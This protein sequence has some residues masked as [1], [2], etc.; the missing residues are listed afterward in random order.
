MK[1]IG[2]SVISKLNLKTHLCIPLLLLL[3]ILD[4]LGGQVDLQRLLLLPHLLRV[5]NGLVPDLLDHFLR[6][7]RGSP[8]VTSAEKVRIYFLTNIQIQP[9]S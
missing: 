8:R 3:F 7:G 4:V 6:D 1:L 9:V 2:M 5:V